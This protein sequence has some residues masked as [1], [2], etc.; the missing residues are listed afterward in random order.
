[1]EKTEEKYLLSNEKDELAEI[2]FN[3]KYYYTGKVHTSTVINNVNKNNT[4]HDI[5]IIEGDHEFKLDSMSIDIFLSQKIQ[6]YKN[7]KFKSNIT[8]NI[9]PY[10]YIGVHY[11]Q[12]NANMSTST[13]T[14]LT[15]YNNILFNDQNGLL[16]NSKLSI[17]YFSNDTNN[18][19][20]NT[21]TNNM[22]NT[23]INSIDLP[24]TNSIYSDVIYFYL[25]SNSEI[26]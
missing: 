1:M 8:D 17:L 5:L 15:E 7:L 3:L 4:E 25:L 9:L 10:K 19:I 11:K 13:S 6:F 23:I 16:I 2:L 26:I 20:C 22:N 24:L 14:G 12:T 21:N 18:I